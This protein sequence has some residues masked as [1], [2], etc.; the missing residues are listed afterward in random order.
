MERPIELYA[1]TWRFDAPTAARYTSRYT[2]GADLTDLALVEKLTSRA[3]SV[4]P[5]VSLTDLRRRREVAL[6]DVVEALEPR[7]HLCA[8]HSSSDKMFFSFVA[9]IKTAAR[10]ALRAPFPVC[11]DAFS[12][13]GLQ[14]TEGGRV[15]TWCSACYAGADRGRLTT[16]LQE[17]VAK[18]P[19]EVSIVPKDDAWKV[20]D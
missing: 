18:Y 7:R 20:W 14:G 19:Q 15:V 1:L 3:K 17:A 16:Q 13:L 11:H 12:F 10:T 8:A 4:E 2:H 5:Y 9:M 6:D